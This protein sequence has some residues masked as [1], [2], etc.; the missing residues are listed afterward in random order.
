MVDVRPFRAYRPSRELASRVA[1]PPYDVLNTEEARE[2]ARGSD[3]SFLHVNKPEIDFP[4][5]HDPYAPDVYA[6]GRENLQAMIAKG[7][8]R[9]EAA[10]CFY[11]YRQR[12]GDHVQTGLV[13]GASVAE[14]ERDLIKKHEFT[15][16]DKED[17]RTRHI[18]E[19]D[20]NDE[21][22]FLTYFARPE[23]DALTARIQAGPP[24]YDF[25]SDDGI[26]H[27]LWVVSN[28]ADVDAMRR[29]FSDVPVLY[30][31]DGHHRSA[32]ATRVCSARRKR[33]GGA[34]AGAEQFLAVLF[35]HDQMKI[36]AYNR[37]VRDLAGMSEE[38]FLARV[39]EGF[40]VTP[41]AKA[42][43]ERER[44][45]G[46]FVGGRWLK[47][48]PKSGTVPEADPVNSLD[49]AIL[50]NNLLRPILGIGDPRTDKR[51]GFVGGIR[52]TAELQKQ[53]ETGKAA[54]AFAL[55]PVSIEQL[56]RV[57]DAGQVMPPKSTWF[58]PKLRSGLFV[59]PL[60]D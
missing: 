44:T 15:R 49:A 9:R 57:A 7:L 19:L 43:P 47:L 8:L 37:V 29:L 26:G 40:E 53:V 38:A 45:F 25:T 36:L 20:A 21:P 10:P 50:Q 33:D 14:Y 60:S 2:M 32:A 23:I 56:I 16:P 55:H 54:V 24:E 42:E 30:V 51:I 17:D 39:R 1:C 22:V 11:I 59:R 58:E 41:A 4:P 6:K 12:M 27:E 31:A 48:A 28:P 13:A 34:A 18:D 5:D 46:M 35:P 3:V 52:G